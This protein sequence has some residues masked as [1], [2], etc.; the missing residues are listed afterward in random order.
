MQNGIQT[1]S[2]LPGEQFWELGLWRR[3]APKSP[4]DG[5]SLLGCLSWAGILEALDLQG[6]VCVGLAM[7]DRHEYLTTG[8]LAILKEL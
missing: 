2:E 7:I 6:S 4:S 8:D 1:L 3:Q 5:D